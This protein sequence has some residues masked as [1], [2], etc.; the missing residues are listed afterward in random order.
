MS[1]SAA[2][3]KQPAQQRGRPCSAAAA[4]AVV[5]EKWALLAV[6]EV[7]YGNRRFDAIARNTGAPRDRLTARLRGL[8]EAGVLERRA[9]S[10]RPRRFEYHLTEAGHELGTVILSLAAWGDRW[11]GDD[12]PPVVFRHLER[13][14]RNRGGEGEWAAPGPDEEPVLTSGREEEHGS[15]HRHSRERGQGRE[16]GQGR[17]R[18]HGQEHGHTA[19]PESGRED[20]EEHRAH[21]RGHR[22]RLALACDTCGHAVRREDVALD[23]NAPGWNRQGPLTDGS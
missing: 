23:I 1:S 12:E 8:E 15:G 13:E 16:H 7:L 19:G 21:E 10:E 11:L 9:Y 5:G 4:L 18:G 2:P 22:L 20:H 6:R 17:E 14:P 3:D